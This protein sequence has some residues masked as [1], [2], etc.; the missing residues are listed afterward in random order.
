[1]P[2][3]DE[4]HAADKKQAAAIAALEAKVKGHDVMLA[5]IVVHMRKTDEAIGSIRQTLGGLATKADILNLSTQI[6]QFNQQQ[7]I[8]SQQTVPAKFAAA[9]AGIMALIT[10]LGFAL[11]HF[12]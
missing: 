5:D 3:I 10:A 8:A 9:C 11:Q 7:L 6:A 1:M 2:T 12:K 4:L